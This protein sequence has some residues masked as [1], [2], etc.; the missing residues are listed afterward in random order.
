MNRP[1]TVTAQP[2]ARTRTM[3]FA[4]CTISLI[5]LALVLAQPFLAGMS[6]DGRLDALDLHR[7]NGLLVVGAA[8]AQTLTAVAWWRLA[9][10][11]GLGP[12]LALLTLVTEVTQ[13]ALGESGNFALHL[14]IGVG[15]VVLALLVSIVALGSPSPQ[16]GTAPR[17]LIAGGRPT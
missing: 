6:L 16:P 17:P 3:R 5:H 12:G 10:G 1:T 4:F 9:Q 2:T 8:T 11:R 13:Y 15:V 7:T 14:P